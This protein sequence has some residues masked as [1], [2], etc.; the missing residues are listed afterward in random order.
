MILSGGSR[1]RCAG[2][3]DELVRGVP[4]GEKP[5]AGGEMEGV[6]LLA[7]SSAVDEPIWCIVK[8]ISDFADK[9]RDSV[10]REGREPACRNAAEFVLSALE[11]DALT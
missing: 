8:G 9:D 6:G 1:I 5:V 11:N 3:R 2:F 10:I 7:A 4:V